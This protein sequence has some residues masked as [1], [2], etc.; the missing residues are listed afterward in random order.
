MLMFM[1][2]DLAQDDRD[3]I[4]VIRISHIETCQ[5]CNPSLCRHILTL[6]DT[7][8]FVIDRR[9]QLVSPGMCSCVLLCCCLYFVGADRAHSINHFLP[10]RRFDTLLKRLM[11]SFMLRIQ[12]PTAK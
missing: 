4:S 1:T 11:Q 10:P 7:L 2:G 6:G 8:E 9:M 12:E 5:R 3:L